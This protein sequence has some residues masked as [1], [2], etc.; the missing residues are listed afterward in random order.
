[1]LKVVDG[2]VTVTA[3]GTTWESSEGW[4][5][6][7]YS[8]ATGKGLVPM[9]MTTPGIFKATVPV[10][11]FK[12]LVDEDPSVAIY[13]IVTTSSSGEYMVLGPD[14]GSTDQKFAIYNVVDEDPEYEVTLDLTEL[15]RRKVVTWKKA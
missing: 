14:Y 3:G 6:H 5:R 11:E 2:K 10:T 9:K 15:D 1:V 7:T 4:A 12:I 13:P 8:V